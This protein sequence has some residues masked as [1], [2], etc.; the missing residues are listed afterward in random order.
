MGGGS[1]LLPVRRGL[2]V[3]T[4]VLTVASAIQYLVLAPRYV[5]WGGR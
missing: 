3:V 2:V 1:E 5:D 4:A